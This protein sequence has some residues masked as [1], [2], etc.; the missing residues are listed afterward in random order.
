M[1]K[2]PETTICNYELKLLFK[3][4]DADGKGDLCERGGGVDLAELFEYLAHGARRPEDEAKRKI[5][6]L[7]RVKKNLQIGFQKL[8]SKE[9][10]E[11]AIRK[12]FNRIDMDGEGKLSPFE[13]NF[14]VRNGLKLSRWDVMNDDLVNF[15]KFMDVDGD[16][17]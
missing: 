1:G 5:Q 13:F 11:M 2:V 10:G 16:G 6:R 15:Y 17:L 9:R 14:F 4:M 7:Q 3:K 12:L 8:S